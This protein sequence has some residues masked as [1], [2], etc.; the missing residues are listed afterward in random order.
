MGLRMTLA[1]PNLLC[2]RRFALRRVEGGFGIKYPV[3][4]RSPS[5]SDAGSN[6]SP[7]SGSDSDDLELIPTP[8]PPKR[9]GTS[10]TTKS[11]KSRTSAQVR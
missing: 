11:S 10:S 6:Y 8:P 9:S 3:T 5:G 2:R 4:L 7:R 1:P